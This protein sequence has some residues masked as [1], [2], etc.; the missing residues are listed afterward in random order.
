MNLNEQPH[1]IY[2]GA[3]PLENTQ[4]IPTVSVPEVQEAVASE[5]TMVT[6]VAEVTP[7]APV[8]PVAPVAEVAPVAPVAEITPV[9]PVVQ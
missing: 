8:A 1:Q 9:A 6:P 5:P 7:I 4:P 2:G 3:N